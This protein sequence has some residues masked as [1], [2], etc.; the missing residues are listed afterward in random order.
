MYSHSR[1][2]GLAVEVEVPPLGGISRRT[3]LIVETDG[4]I[5][6][7]SQIAAEVREA[8]IHD[9][10]DVLKN[11]PETEIRLVVGKGKHA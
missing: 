6:P 2:L 10:V 8:A 7:T 3:F 4:E 11:P 9:W 5:Y 1:I